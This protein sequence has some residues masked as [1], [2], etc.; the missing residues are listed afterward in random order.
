MRAEL[1]GNAKHHALKITGLSLFAWFALSQHSE[2]PF[3]C[4]ASHARRF[5]MRTRLRPDFAVVFFAQPDVPFFRGGRAG[6][7]CAWSVMG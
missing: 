5:Q 1:S 2:I 7:A 4:A 6:P 3:P